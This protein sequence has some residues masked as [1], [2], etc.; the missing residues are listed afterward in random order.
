MGMGKKMFFPGLGAVV[1]PPC[2]NQR[3]LQA[4]FPGSR[5]DFSG[6]PAAGASGTPGH[7][8]LLVLINPY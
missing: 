2:Q 7:G 1:Q 6:V 4:A 8:C 3:L 5:E